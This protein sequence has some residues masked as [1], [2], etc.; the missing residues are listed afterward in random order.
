[1]TRAN[2]NRLVLADTGFWIAYYEERDE[3]H[4]QAV[5]MFD[6]WA[7]GT[8]LFP[9]PLYYELLRTRFVKHPKWVRSFR[10]VVADQRIKPIDDQPYRQSALEQTFASAGDRGRSISLA[11]WVLRLVLDDQ[12]WRIAR[13]VTFNSRDFADVCRRRGIQILTAD[14]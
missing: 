10:H 14:Q 6:N 9:W 1:M 4:A 2:S 8:F 5:R 11:D 7:L 13:L 3:Y 12:N